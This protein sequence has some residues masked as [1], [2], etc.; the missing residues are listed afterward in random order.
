MINWITQYAKEKNIDLIVMG[1][2]GKHNTLEKTFG[3]V[4]TGVVRKAPCP[5]LVIPEKARFQSIE[6]VGYATNLNE[7]DSCNIW[8]LGKFFEGLNPSIHCVHIN[9]E[10]SLEKILDLANLEHSFN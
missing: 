4:T 10:Q 5:V 6:A 7:T 2:R 9:V 8:K 3:T 1:T